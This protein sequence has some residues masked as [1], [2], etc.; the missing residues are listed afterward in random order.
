MPL[1][2]RAL[3]EVFGADAPRARLR[4]VSAFTDVTLNFFM[5]QVRDELMRKKASP[6]HVQGLGQSIAIHLARNYAEKIRDPQS[7]SPSLPGFKLRQI[8]A[9]MAGHLAEEFNLQRLETQAGLSKFHF[10]RLFKRTTGGSPSRY[11]L[12]LPIDAARQL[13]R[14]TKQSI[15]EVGLEVGYNNA[16]RFAQLFRRETGLTPSE[17]RRQ[18]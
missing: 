18:R 3:V 1:L 14:E 5:E 11:H 17:Y 4:D 13:L 2:Q 16:S 6:L 10:I 8:T 15:V 7:A 9:G 12:T